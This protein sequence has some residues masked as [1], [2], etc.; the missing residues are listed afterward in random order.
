MSPPRLVPLSQR[1][2][3]P[4][5]FLLVL[6]SYL[7]VVPLL[8]LDY[9]FVIIIILDEFLVFLLP[10]NWPFFL[11]YGLRRRVIS[12]LLARQSVFYTRMHFLPAPSSQYAEV[13]KSFTARVTK[14]EVARNETL[15]YREQAVHV[16]YEKR[17]EQRVTTAGR[18]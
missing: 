5:L 4:G 14:F 7:V 10:L 3:A 2:S 15:L 6:Y 16:I 11:L 12:S 17:S 13:F 18:T 1:I 8:P 9:V